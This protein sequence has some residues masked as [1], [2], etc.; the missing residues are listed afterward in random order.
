MPKRKRTH[1]NHE[2]RR[3]TDDISLR[4]HKVNDSFCRAKKQFHHVLKTAK[5]FER[6]KLGKRLKRA[7]T[8]ELKAR[9]TTEI[10][11]LKTLDL[12]KVVNAHLCNTL[13]KVK[14]FTKSGLLPDGITKVEN[15]EIRNDP[16]EDA[17]LNNVV[18]GML[19]MKIVKDTIE[20]IINET[21]L[22]MGIPV[23]ERKKRLNN[24]TAGQ[25]K[26]VQIPKDSETNLADNIL[27][28]PEWEGFES[29]KEETN[30]ESANSSENENS[31]DEYTSF[32]AQI[33]N[34]SD[35]ESFDETAY[36]SKPILEPP[37]HFSRSLSVSSSSN[38]S[39]SS[40]SLSLKTKSQPVDIKS[41]STRKLKSLK[42]TKTGLS[43]TFLP[44]LM[45][46]YWSGSEESASDLENF[47]PAT[48]KNRPGQMARRAI[49]EKKFGKMANH[50]RLGKNSRSL[51]PDK[52]NAVRDSDW[53][54]R[55]GAINDT[56]ARMSH[57]H[58][59]GRYTKNTDMRDKPYLR[60]LSKDN[61]LATNNHVAQKP[62]L[63]NASKGI[64]IKELGKSR[65]DDLGVLHPSW[66]AAKKAK[67]LK[68]TAKFQGQ[69]IVF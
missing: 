43:S 52:R 1:T 54:P 69:K 20:Q 58:D 67:E 55:R 56:T 11:V 62:R 13:L 24:V 19:N 65:R 48:K 10:K 42:S 46:G 31:G 47:T 2:G 68:Q 64:N 38:I 4:Q 21:Y 3:E 66:Q 32:Q 16:A 49:A 61:K 63:Q 53:D 33:G 35:E 45:G 44:T 17:A 57:G 30:N 25:N 28:S 5:N 60:H 8:D 29:D 26:D 40:E 41:N 15:R 27:T 18:S 51:P 59:Q 23:P 7:E 50:I 14:N 36:K 12:D 6:Q 9:I 22:A 39:S 37:S 34:S